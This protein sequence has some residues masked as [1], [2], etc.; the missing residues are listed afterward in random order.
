[1]IQNLN[2]AD[3]R[4]FGRPIGGEPPKN[5][6]VHSLTLPPEQTAFYQAVAPVRLSC[7]SGITV[8]SVS[9][10]GRQY[11]DYYLDRP[12]Q[13]RPGVYFSL[14]PVGDG[15]AVG[16]SAYSMPLSL[17][18]VLSRS[19]FQVR[20]QLHI[21]SLSAFCYQEKEPGFYFP[22]ES[23]ATMELLYA[24]RG[25][26]HSVADGR[27]LTLQPGE[28]VLYGPHQW[29]MQYARQDVAPRI[30]SLLF[31]AS[32]CDLSSL[33]NRR[34]PAPRP[35]LD[36]LQKMLREQAHPDAYSQD[37]ILSLLQ[38]LLLTLL[39]QLPA[40]QPALQSSAALNGENQV[41]R[42]AQQYVAAHV[43]EKLSVPELAQSC[44]VSPSYLSFLFQ[45]HLQISPGEYIRRI[46]LQQSKHMIREG[47]QNITQ[48]AEALQYSTIHHFSRQFKEKFGMTPTEYAK[49]VKE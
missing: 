43:F 47:N 5:A 13:L 9:L 1:M 39:R 36:I 10:D 37:M 17:G 44:Q 30:V 22:G 3:F 25:C 42:R 8:L 23:H 11:Q 40:P 2:P 6:N 49:S 41:I 16:L 15:S 29:H 28:F 32:G 21:E 48:I 31:D 19:T 27:E 38:Q 46:K 4:R 34:L 45:K 14:T 35:A 26:F 24:D 12:V 18:A 7:E 33:Y 20:Q